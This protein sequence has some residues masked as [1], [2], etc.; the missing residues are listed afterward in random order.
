MM[1]SSC[2]ERTRTKV[3]SGHFIGAEQFFYSELMKSD[4]KSFKFAFEYKFHYFS[5]EN[6]LKYR[7][8]TLDP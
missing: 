8:L 4:I 6:S 3:S 7:I 1:S 5:L 2:S